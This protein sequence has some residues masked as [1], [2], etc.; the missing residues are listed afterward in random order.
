MKY[1]KQSV[2]IFSITFFLFLFCAEI[3]LRFNP[4]ILFP[5]SNFLPD[6]KVTKKIRNLR[7]QKENDLRKKTKIGSLYFNLFMGEIIAKSNKVDAK[8]GENFIYNY[9]DGFCNN[10]TNNKFAE[11][12]A[13]GDSFTNC[14]A[15]KPEE[16]WIY[17]IFKNQNTKLTYNYG[18]GGIGPIHYNEI[19]REKINKN[20]KIIFYG[21]YEGND[22]RD[23]IRF[24]T[25]ENNSKKV[26]TSTDVNTS[27]KGKYPFIKKI[28]GDLYSFNYLWSHIKYKILNK[29]NFKYYR[30]IKDKKENF[31]I[32]NSDI[33]EVEFAEKILIHK[34][35]KFFRNIFETN[36]KLSFLEAQK[37]S[38]T[39]DAI[40]IFVYLPSA[41][42][43]F[44]KDQVVFEDKNLNVLMFDYS[45]YVQKVFKKI[46]KANNL[47]CV[48]IIDKF[49][50]KNKN[51]LTPSH[52]PYNVHFTPLGHKILG[53]ELRVFFCKNF[54]ENSFCFN[55]N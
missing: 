41:Y 18:H 2:I 16:T 27:N 24:K 28:F 39:N 47:M 21:F 30:H 4:K 48:N 11:I 25:N 32:G 36:L 34:N 31:N 43:A 49:I 42:S 23:I 37:I 9:Q 20:T 17:N 10:H 51:S 54:K 40:I 45:N 1:F 50:E 5:L 26:T 7:T 3:Y 33:D 38:K 46:C 55:Q 6:T 52:F 19:L 8:Y 13:V 14:T 15:V 53:K 29:I 12:I 35:K 44:G 22:I